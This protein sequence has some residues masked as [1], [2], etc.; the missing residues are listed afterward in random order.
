MRR[1]FG[2]D[3]VRINHAPSR[4]VSSIASGP[5]EGPKTRAMRPQGPRDCVETVRSTSSSRTLRGRSR[6]PISTGLGATRGSESMGRSRPLRRI[7]RS[8]GRSTTMSRQSIGPSIRGGLANDRR[9]RSRGRA[10]RGGRR[11]AASGG[12]GGASGAS[13][14]MRSQGPRE[15]DRV[16][17]HACTTIRTA[18]LLWSV[19]SGSIIVASHPA[20]LAVRRSGVIEFVFAPRCTTTQRS[21]GGIACQRSSGGASGVPFGSLRRHLGRGDSSCWPRLDR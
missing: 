16:I 1:P 13:G 12:R 21:T 15:A 4:G 18:A 19:P 6:G 14:S 7:A 11:R 5:A 17:G 2:K 3:A 9:S 8:P 20:R 10:S